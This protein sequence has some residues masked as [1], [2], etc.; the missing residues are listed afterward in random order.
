MGFFITLLK[1]LAVLGVL[2]ALALAALYFA[3]KHV[4]AARK[5]KAQ[6][7]AKLRQSV[8]AKP[9][10][11]ANPPSTPDKR[12]GNYAFPVTSSTSLSDTARPHSSRQSLTPSSSLGTSKNHHHRPS[13]MVQSTKNM[14]APLANPL[15]LGMRKRLASF[16]TKQ[17]PQIQEHMGALGFEASFNPM[18][19]AGFFQ[20]G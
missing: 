2:A 8:Q 9:A 3:N 14:V 4:R 1:G 6:E 10:A 19:E 15:K 18:F 13:T 16:K 11:P 17:A 20:N 7:K 5:A 12:A